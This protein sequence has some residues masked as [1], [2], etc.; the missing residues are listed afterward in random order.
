MVSALI[1]EFLES[2]HYECF[3]LIIEFLIKVKNITKIDI[4]V[5]KFDN[6]IFLNDWVSFFQ[7]NFKDIVSI[8]L[9]H[10]LPPDKK[11]AIN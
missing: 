2:R 1:A 10:S 9:I 11:K 5:P 8:R 7:L 4:Y 6:D 3:G